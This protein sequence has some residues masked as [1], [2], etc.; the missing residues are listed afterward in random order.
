[1]VS[2]RLEEVVEKREQL[3]ISVEK[4]SPKGVKSMKGGKG[5]NPFSINQSVSIAL[6]KK[7]QKVLVIDPKSPLG[8]RNTKTK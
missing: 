1:M 2:N 5:V 7:H 8:K 6:N 3:K 4:K